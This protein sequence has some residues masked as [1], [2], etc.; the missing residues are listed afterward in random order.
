MEGLESAD[1]V[2]KVGWPPLPAAKHPRPI[3]WQLSVFKPKLLLDPAVPHA[4]GK[5]AAVA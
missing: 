4:G 5:F 1:I 2:Q 3:S